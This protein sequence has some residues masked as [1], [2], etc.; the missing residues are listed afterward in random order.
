MSWTWCD[1]TE[2]KSPTSRFA[3]LFFF[4]YAW[5]DSLSLSLSLSLTSCLISC[6]SFCLSVSSPILSFVSLSSLPAPPPLHPPHPSHMF[7][8]PKRIFIHKNRLNPTRLKGAQKRVAQSPSGSVANWL[9]G[10]INSASSSFASFRNHFW[11]FWKLILI[12][13]EF[14]LANFSLPTPAFW[15]SDCERKASKTRI[16]L[17]ATPR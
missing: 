6:L 3:G 5:I 1:A 15:N 16:S 4:N 10:S 8:L 17:I 12:S 9:T 2:N 13:D 11:I 7:C 14:R